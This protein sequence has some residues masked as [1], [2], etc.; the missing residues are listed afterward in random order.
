[1]SE[2]LE[3]LKER[4][5]EVADIAAASSVLSWDQQV[6]LPVHG[7]EAR[8]QQLA[9]LNKIAQEKFI[10]DEVGQLIEALQQEFAG[11]DPELDEAAMVRVAIQRPKSIPRSPIREMAISPMSSAFCTRR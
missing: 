1:M 8:G 7:N 11:A 4:L 6:N 2:K 9:T 3:Q 5:G 10:A